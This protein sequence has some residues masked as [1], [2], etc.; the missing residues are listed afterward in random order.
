MLHKFNQLQPCGWVWVFLPSSSIAR[1]DSF[2][3]LQ[4][5]CLF[6]CLSTATGVLVLVDN[7]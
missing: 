1:S 2:K 3:S 6:V 7:G 4:K 5:V